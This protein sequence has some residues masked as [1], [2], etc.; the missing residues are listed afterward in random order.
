MTAEWEKKMIGKVS[1]EGTKAVS[2]LW[3]NPESRGQSSNTVSKGSGE[4]VGLEIFRA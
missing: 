2:K 4:V 1:T 3:G